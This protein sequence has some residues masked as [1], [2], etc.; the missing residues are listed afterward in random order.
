VI[1]FGGESRS[2]TYE[3]FMGNNAYYFAQ[4]LAGG[5]YGTSGSATV[6]FDRK[7]YLVTT[8]PV[9]VLVAGTTAIKKGNGMGLFRYDEDTGNWNITLEYAPVAYDWGAGG[10]GTAPNPGQAWVTQVDIPVPI[11]VFDDQIAVR[12]NA[13]N[14]TNNIRVNHNTG[15]ATP[16][17]PA[18]PDYGFIDAVNDKWILE[19]TYAV[20]NTR[21]QRQLKFDEAMFRFGNYFSG[22]PYAGGAT[23][24]AIPA[25]DLLTYAITPTAGITIDQAAHPDFVASPAT[26]PAVATPQG[27]VLRDFPVPVFYRRQLLTSED[28]V[29]IDIISGANP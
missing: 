17:T 8:D 2:I 26:P 23:P 18:P 3:E 22:T 24:T 20:G 4:N 16:I 11:Y 15:T 12:K 7:D 19:G 5:S 6:A 21:V 10:T 27:T 29:L 14:G 28:T 9:T 13:T 25:T 1:Y